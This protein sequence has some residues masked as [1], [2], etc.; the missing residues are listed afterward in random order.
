MPFSR[1]D[2]ASRGR[3]QT[4][5]SRKTKVIIGLALLLIAALMAG[6]T[7][8]ASAASA[9]TVTRV[10]PSSGP[11]KGGQTVVVTGV[12]FTG[13]TGVKFGTTAATS[14]AVMNDKQIVAVV[15]DNA[16][17]G[18]VLVEVTNATGANTTGANYEYKA[19]KITKVDPGWGKK[20]ADNFITITGEGLDGT[21]AADV[22]FG[23]DAAQNV[24]VISDK[25][26]V[27]QPAK[28]DGSTVTITDGV[29]DVVVTR[30]SVAT[31]PDAKSKFLF[32]PGLPTVT[33]L[34]DGSSTVVTGTD[35]VAAGSTMT[36]IGTQLWGLSQVT[37]G[38]S[39]VT[40]SSD[41]S[42]N[43]GGTEA[44]VKVPTRSAG[45]VDVTVTN[46]AGT[47]ITN[48]KTTFSYYSSTAPSITKVYP[49]AFA[50]AS[51]GTM[52]VTG[53]G[54]TGVTTSEVTL[55]CATGTP[56]ATSATSISDTS[57]ILVLSANGTNVESCDL[58][59]DNPTD[60]N[61]TV[62]KTAAIRYI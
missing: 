53:R 62:T 60:S 6:P 19:P 41:I 26:I 43:S 40:N 13:T 46:A 55:T 38:T 18:K 61:L 44:T 2:S 23:T 58:K 54:L 39:R 31:T 5:K 24:W 14:Y 48:L 29:T 45:P 7:L 16:T 1:K 51:G 8:P 36:I 34:E 22:K 33:Q 4:R 37:F 59:I 49:E 17:A 57:L 56:T 35:G 47:S 50:K 20:D 32:T 25:Q 10:S 3:I 52:L 12:D 30:N 21:V 15:P 9:P 28:H 42:V 11:L 27:V